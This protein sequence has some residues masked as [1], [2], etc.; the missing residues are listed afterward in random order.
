MGGRRLR[1]LITGGSGMLGSDILPVL[2]RQFEVYAP[3][4]TQLD[5]T[6]FPKVKQTVEEGKFDWVIHLAAL[7]DLDWC[8]DHPEIAHRVNA[9]AT[10]FLAEVSKNA[11]AKFAYISTSGIFDGKKR[12]PYTEHDIPSPINVYG[13]SKYEGEKFV[14]EVFGDKGYLILRVGW[15]FGGGAQ[16]KKFVGKMFQLLREKEQVLAVNDIVGSPNYSVDIGEAIVKLIEGDFSGI[17]HI[18]NSGEPASRYDIATAMKEFMNSPTEIIPVSAEKFPTKA[19]RPPME[20]IA[21]VKLEDA[22][23]HP[24]RHWREALEEYIHRLTR[25]E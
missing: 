1:V 7:T 6:D 12:N 23:G 22:L 25:T 8:E 21:S 5:I 4:R 17:F 19:P 11:G 3:P 2:E 13:K 14:R 20:A 9:E 15:L 16:D 18:A 10:G 24:M